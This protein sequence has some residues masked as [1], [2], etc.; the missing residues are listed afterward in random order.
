MLDNIR[1]L[2]LGYR[3]GKRAPD[4]DALSAWRARNL[5]PAEKRPKVICVTNQKG[6]CGKTTTAINL[7]AGLARYGFRVL[8]LDLD[9]QANSSLGLGVDVDNLN[10]SAYDVFARGLDLSYAVTRTKVKNLDIVAA[11]RLLSGVPLE[12]ANMIGRETVLKTAIDKMVT[13]QPERYDYLIMDCSPSLD[14]ITLNALVAARDVLVPIQSHY[15]ALEGMRDLLSTLTIIQ[16]RFNPDLKILGIV[17]TMYDG[18]AR[19]NREIHGQI[20][21]FFED[22]MFS[23]LIRMNVKLIEAQAR[24]MSIFDY[25]P[26][27]PAA[28][29]Y[30]QLAR[31]VIGRTRPG[32]PL[33]EPETAGTSPVSVRPRAVTAGE[34]SL[35]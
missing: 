21:G 30:D 33:P 20:R 35:L 24:G 6:G 22:K 9:P 18:R 15:F 2:L 4:Q 16:E 25:Q 10:S 12:I 34:P 28:L 19:I 7:S 27:A 29:D 17:L 1:N 3:A 5:L 11:N 26:A 13:L 14:L 32:E 23:S 8:L 31:E